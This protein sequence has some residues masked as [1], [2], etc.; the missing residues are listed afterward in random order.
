M[1]LNVIVSSEAR[2]SAR[3]LLLA[4]IAG[5]ITSGLG[6]AIWYRALRGLTA[7]QGAVLQLS[8]P[9]IAAGGAVA[10]LGETLSPRLVVAAAAVLGG[11]SLVLSQRVRPATA[12]DPHAATEAFDPRDRR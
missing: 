2:T 9:V 12:V 6:Y 4:L 3:G 7:T 5:G 10:L 1:F 11:V 8:V